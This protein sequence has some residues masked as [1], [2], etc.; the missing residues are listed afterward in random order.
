[1]LFLGY[2]YC[3]PFCFMREKAI[4]I[5]PDQYEHT[6]DTSDLVNGINGDLQFE[7]YSQASLGQ[8][9]QNIRNT[10][11]GP[12]WNSFVPDDQVPTTDVRREY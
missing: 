2:C 12:N 4:L 9:D 7:V 11:S 8:V 5:K 1:M 6:A 3:N 10:S